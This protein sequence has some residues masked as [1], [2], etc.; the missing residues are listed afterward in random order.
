MTITA[1][2]IL[3]VV[4]LI[5]TIAGFNQAGFLDKYCT[6]PYRIKRNKEYYRLL[7]GGFLHVSW[8][9]FA[10]NMFV[11]WQFGTIVE[12]FYIQLFGPFG[13][14]L[15]VVMYL[16]T[17]VLASVP[18]LLKKSDN[19]DF[20]SVGA[21]GGVSGIL[22]IYILFAPW[23]MLYLYAIIPIPGIVAG[24]AYLIYS[25]YASKKSNDNIDHSA[26]F[27]GALAGVVITLA[28][29]PKILIYFF[30]RLIND[31]PL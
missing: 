29:Y 28:L 8:L 11:F 21:S 26:H 31:F 22:F 18:G 13:V 1:T 5:V 2:I 23:N 14:G 15:Y 12:H 7:T 27:W 10:V 25:S 17:I 20:R 19:Y 9:H 16:A 4:N 24:V 6:W 30:N 3:I